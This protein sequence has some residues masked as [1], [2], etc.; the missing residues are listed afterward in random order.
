M[1]VFESAGLYPEERKASA[2]PVAA[3]STSTYASAGWLRKGPVNQATLVIGFDNFVEQ[4]G[5][6]WRNSYVPFMVEAFFNN[7]GAR[8]YI[9]RVVPTDATKA[10]NASCLDAAATSATFYSR[11]LTDY[12]VSLFSCNC[13]KGSSSVCPTLSEYEQGLH[14]S[15]DRGSLYH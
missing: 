4:F 2:G 1:P 9:T 12:L 5:S 7:E 11:K 3:V 15:L 13:N 10:A 6:Y 14:S 8:A